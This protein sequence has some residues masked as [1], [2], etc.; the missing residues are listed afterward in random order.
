MSDKLFIV[1]MI[2]VHCAQ[3]CGSERSIPIDPPFRSAEV[4]IKFLAIYI[5]E[6]GVK[7]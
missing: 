1:D 3:G 7:S 5:Q 4:F 2:I 6:T